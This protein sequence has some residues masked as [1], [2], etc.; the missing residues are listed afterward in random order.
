M[1]DNL[2]I[3][4]ELLDDLAGKY[5][6]FFIG[7]KTYGVELL[8]VLEIISIQS[9]TTVPSTPVYVKGIINLRGRIVPVIDVRLKFNMQ[10]RDYDER[11][12][13]VVLNIDEMYVGL[14]VDQ[15]SE[16]ITFNNDSLASLPDFGSVNTNQYL[17]SIA[18]VKDKLVLNLDCEKF[19]QDDNVQVHF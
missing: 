19:L 4:D 10:E 18:K 3:A 2:V 13:I 8:H 9:V 17:K 14:I 15:V 16:V 6:T 1:S 5:L 11:T 12:C 7:D